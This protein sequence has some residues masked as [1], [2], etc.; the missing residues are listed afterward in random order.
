MN[1]NGLMAAKVL[2]LICAGVVFVWWQLRDLAKE[3]ERRTKKEAVAREKQAQPTDTSLLSKDE[4]F[5]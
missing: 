4:E 2:I 1:A 5:R 3:K